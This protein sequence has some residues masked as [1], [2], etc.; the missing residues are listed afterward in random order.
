MKIKKGNGFMMIL[1]KNATLYDPAYRGKKDVLICFDRILAIG[2]GLEPCFPDTEVIDATGKLLIP[3]LIDQHVHFIGGGGEQGPSS[4]TP[5][6]LFSDVVQAGVTTLVGVLGTD[7]VTRSLEALLAKTKAL[8]EE[9][10]TAYCLTSAYCYP[11]LTVTGSVMRDIVLL[12]EVIGC[13]LALS[14]H[15]GSHPTREEIIR[16]ASDVRMAGLVGNKPGVLHIHIGADPAGIEPILDI[17]RSTDLPAW[18]FRPTHMTRHPKQAAEFTQMGGYADFT[19][20]DA[21]PSVLKEYRAELD[22]TH[23]TVSSDANG[24]KPKWDAAHENVIGMGVG[25]MTSLLE[26][27]RGFV[28]EGFALEDALPLF[29]ENVAKALRLYPRKGTVQE[30][31]DAD[32]VLLEEDYSVHSVFA[33]GR[34]LMQDGKILVRGMY[35]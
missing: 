22:L 15:R 3:G 30:G 8:N 2:E 26:T 11:P 33:K 23:V 18:N 29:T 32:L 6:L 13:K 4:R 9:G 20:G 7:C 21:L 16:L 34:K 25:K 17:V 31:A 14:D 28:N 1:L 12:S 27:L 5:E 35:E 10:V 19:A 24:S